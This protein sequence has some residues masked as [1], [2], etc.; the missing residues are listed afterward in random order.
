MRRGRI[1]HIGQQFKPMP[2]EHW[3]NIQ[4]ALLASA[5]WV[6][7]RTQGG[8]VTEEVVLS[9]LDTGGETALQP[10]DAMLKGLHRA[11]YR[12]TEANRFCFGCEG[13][14]KGCDCPANGHQRFAGAIAH[15][16]ARHGAF[17]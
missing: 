6:H 2:A 5:K 14:W 8:D 3:K 12:S 13:I 7:C 9:A 17:Q 16:T 10:I 11:L 1:A 15:R 4:R